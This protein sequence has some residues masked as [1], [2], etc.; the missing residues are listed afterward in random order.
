MLNFYF[1]VKCCFSFSFRATNIIKKLKQ[2]AS[3]FRKFTPLTLS[4]IYMLENSLAKELFSQQ[5]QSVGVYIKIWLV[6]LE[7]VSA[8][9]LCLI[10]DKADVVKTP[11]SG[12]SEWGDKELLLFNHPIDFSKKLGP[13]AQ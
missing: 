1:Y 11:P 10:D 7:N 3:E 6:Y 5:A 13:S 4:H 12:I 9:D 8:E 2:F